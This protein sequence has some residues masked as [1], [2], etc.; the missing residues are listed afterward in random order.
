MLRLEGFSGPSRTFLELKSDEISDLAVDT[1]P[2]NAFHL[3]FGIADA[4]LGIERDRMIQLQARSGKRD[5]FEIRDGPVRTTGFI[6]PLD[7]YQIR[8]KHARLETP[9]LHTSII[10]AQCAEV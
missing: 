6:G 9:V 2:H 3:P 8:A 7:V 10:V 5:V 1:V 4:E